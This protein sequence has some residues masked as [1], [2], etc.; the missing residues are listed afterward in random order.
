MTRFLDRRRATIA[1][2]VLVLSLASG[3][4]QQAVAATFTVIDDAGPAG[5]YEVNESWS[6]RAVDANGD[7]CQDVWIGYH[8]QGG[9]LWRGDCAGAYTRIAPGAWPRRNAEGRIPD[10]HECDWA[11]VDHNG[12]PDAACATG[13]G[14]DNQ[15]KHGKDNELWL[16]TAVSTFVEVGTQWGMGDL[17]GRSHYLRFLEANGDGWVDLVVGN[18][19]PRPVTG[20]PCDDPANGLPNEESKLFLNVAGQR[21]QQAPASF[22][23]G[24]YW[25]VRCL[26]VVDWNRDGWRDLLACSQEGLKLFRNNAGNGFTNIS[27]SIGLTATNYSDADLADLDGDGDLDLTAILWERLVYR[28]NSGGRLGSAVTIRTFQGGRALA[29][30]DAD[31]NGTLDI[32]VLLARL[33][34]GI[35]SDDILLLN[36]GLRF[37]AL[38]VPPA[39]GM[40]DAVVPLDGDDNGRAEFL[41]LNGQ[42]D[43][44]GP[45]QLI[46]LVPS[47]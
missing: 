8:D 32:Y 28:L 6:A 5:L 31:G 16:Q 1:G 19:P 24:G 20:D 9:K 40:G 39:G 36:A 2:L 23:I 11:D 14:G 13:R 7:G 18:A 27:A 30:G 17:C 10:R 44:R 35:N 12:L 47:G 41:V 38:A 45:V 34:A 15:V 25:G 29:V 26:E 37:T 46:K 22:G 3:A 4:S 21:F 43:H 33:Q 42:E